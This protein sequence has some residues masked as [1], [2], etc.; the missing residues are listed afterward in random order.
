M[1]LN[2]WMQERWGEGLARPVMKAKPPATLNSVAALLNSPTPVWTDER[3]R[4][5]REY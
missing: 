2:Q 1:W 5:T 4:V 3:V